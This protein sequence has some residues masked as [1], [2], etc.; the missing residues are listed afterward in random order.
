MAVGDW[1]R[2]GKTALRIG[3]PQDE[4]VHPGGHVG[5]GARLKTL[6]LDTRDKCQQTG[7]EEGGRI[8]PQVR[9]GGSRRRRAGNCRWRCGPEILH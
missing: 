3:V 6:R 8:V 7:G 1:Q 9:A 5:V 4:E 2:V